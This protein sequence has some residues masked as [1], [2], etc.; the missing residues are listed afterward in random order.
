MGRIMDITPLLMTFGLIAIAEL[1]DK[2]QLTVIALSAGY[3]RVKVFTG[4]ILGFILVTGLGILVGETLF[5]YISPSW[6]KIIAGL[7]FI[8]FGI[9]ILLSQKKSCDTE[10]NKSLSNPLISTFSMITLA[11][12][13]DKTQLS[14]ITLAAKFDSPYFVFLG[15]ILALGLITLI[16]ILVGE[17]LCK[18]VPLS[19]IRLGAGVVFIL[20][21]ILF[22]AGF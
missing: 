10:E 3:D 4:A 16:G 17:K 9:W 20:F 18:I 12:M 5:T 8:V 13:G 22:L 6:I 1:G 15:A 14:A 11:E 2:T 19:K 21:G 7:L